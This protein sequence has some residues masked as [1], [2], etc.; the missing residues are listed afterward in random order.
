[1][2]VDWAQARAFE[3]ES[4]RKSQEEIAVIEVIIELQLQGKIALGAE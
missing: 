2:R 3:T 1:M 4:V